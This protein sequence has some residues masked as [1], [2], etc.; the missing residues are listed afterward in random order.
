MFA[1]GMRGRLVRLPE[2]AGDD[3]GTT[4]GKEPPLRLAVLGD[5]VAAG[6]GAASHGE[7]MAGQLA[8][9]LTAMTGRAVSWRV[10]AKAGAT[11]A[12]VRR[13]MLPGL[14]DPAA[15]WRPDL[16]VV[17]AGTNDAMRLRRP[18]AFRHDA[19]RLVRDVRLRLGEDVPMVFAGLPTIAR[20]SS[21]P[22]RVRG[23]LGLYIGLLDRQLRTTATRGVAVF[24]L[25]SGGPPEFPGDWLAAD[26]F[27][28]SPAGYRAWARVL[29]SRLATL[30][31]AT[32]PAV[33]APAAPTRPIPSNAG[34]ADIPSPSGV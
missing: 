22:R 33:L 31:E 32:L 24:H 34:G 29:A 14:T 2:A 4:E 9:A 11:L 5:S 8:E 6:V 7:A 18:R 16:V 1:K 19:E 30:T 27:H 13:G 12:A 3:S 25:P 20:L 23:P 28:P 21:L 26:R 17:V 15:R 10:A